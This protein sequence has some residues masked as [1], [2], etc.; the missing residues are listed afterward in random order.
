[1]QKSGFSLP[2]RRDSKHHL[3]ADAA[4]PSGAGELLGLAGLPE[5][6]A[7]TMLGGREV[8]RG[9]FARR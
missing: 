2:P 6:V 5:P 3:P 8:A 9:V 1:M 7:G 4:F